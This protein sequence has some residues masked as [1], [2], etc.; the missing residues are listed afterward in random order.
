MTCHLDWSLL[1]SKVSEALKNFI[2]SK[3]NE[4]CQTRIQEFNKKKK[5]GE[6]QDFISLKPLAKVQVTKIWWGTEPPLLEIME[7]SEAPPPP[8]PPKKSA[9]VASTTQTKKSS[10]GATPNASFPSVHHQQQQ[11][12][13]SNNFLGSPLASLGGAGAA[14]N[15]SRQDS[16][17]SSTV[18]SSS[19]PFSFNNTK[20][21]SIGRTNNN[22]NNNLQRNS[23]VGGMNSKNN[24]NNRSSNKQHQP[25]LDRS[26]FVSSASTTPSGSCNAIPNQQRSNMGSPSS[27]SQQQPQQQQSSPSILNEIL[28]QNGFQ[29]RI[30]LVHSGSAGFEIFVDPE[31]QIFSPFSTLLVNQKK[32]SDHSESKEKFETRENSSVNDYDNDNNYDDGTEEEKSNSF[33]LRDDEDENM[34]NIRQDESNEQDQKNEFK[35]QQENDDDNSD[36]EKT[37]GENAPL[38]SIRFP[39]LFDISDFHFDIVLNITIRGEEGITVRI[40]PD[41]FG[42]EGAEGRILSSLSIVAKAGAGLLHHRHQDNDDEE[43]SSSRNETAAAAAAFEN[44]EETVIDQDCARRLVLKELRAIL[45][46]TLVRG[47]VVP[48]QKK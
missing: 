13:P 30:H 2:N 27:P 38:A 37:E 32:S 47:I 6:T 18:V 44:V 42:G 26:S 41:R 23:V 5:Q 48:L 9:I 21:V 10:T 15:I 43:E 16:T 7:I 1:D 29:I 28:G 25:S 33:L 39:M 45:V 40:E 8:P 12:H 22:N 11:Q 34:N 17:S 20:N 24:N 14:S 46:R 19:S 3:L 36:D 4:I 31:L 35:G